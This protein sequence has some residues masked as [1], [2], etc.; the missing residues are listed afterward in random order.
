[1]NLKQI[2]IGTMSVFLFACS[3]GGGGGTGGGNTP[4]NPATNSSILTANTTNFEIPLADVNQAKVKTIVITN[5]GTGPTVALSMSITGQSQISVNFSDCQGK[6]LA[7]SESCSIVFSLTSNIAS[8]YLKTVTVISG[9]PVLAFPVVGYVYNSAEISY[10][11]S[12]ITGKQGI[13][14]Q[15][16]WDFLDSDLANNAFIAHALAKADSYSSVFLFTPNINFTTEPSANWLSVD[17]A[18]NFLLFDTDNT[19]L[20]FDPAVSGTDYDTIQTKWSDTIYAR[21]KQLSPGLL[22]KENQIYKIVYGIDFTAFS[23]VYSKYLDSRKIITVDGANNPT[24][25]TSSPKAQFAYLL[26]NNRWPSGYFIEDAMKEVNFLFEAYI[27]LG[28]TANINELSR[29]FVQHWEYNMPELQNLVNPLVNGTPDIFVPGINL[30]YNPIEFNYTTSI[31]AGDY[32]PYSSGTGFGSGVVNTQ[33]W[34]VN[35]YQNHGFGCR[36]LAY[37]VL[38]LV[39]AYN[40]GNWTSPEKTQVGNLVKDGIIEMKQSA[41]CKYNSLT[42]KYTSQNNSPSGFNNNNGLPIIARI[43]RLLPDSIVPRSE[44]TDIYNQLVQELA[45]GGSID[46]DNSSGDPLIR[47]EVLD[48]LMSLK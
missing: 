19:L 25:S 9:G 32:P 41:D 20:Q 26:D 24:G 27:G 42:K 22:Y 17:K 7:V 12:K 13:I 2:L 40:N 38:N 33:L 46:L 45:V 15:G 18:L 8:S 10:M 11:I 4:V 48:F 44:K 21:P 14:H 6:I 37:T 1:M 35:D 30:R 31:I 34:F 23:T 47:A 43:Y 39:Y 36:N 5:T 28:Q 29:I 16:S 3:G